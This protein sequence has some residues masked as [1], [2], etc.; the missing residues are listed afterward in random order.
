[1]QFDGIS[2]QLFAGLP[3]EQL[4]LFSCSHVVARENVLTIC[5]DTG[6]TNTVLDF[7]YD[8]RDSMVKSDQYAV[9]D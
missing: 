8:K 7:R 9:T 6:P 2:R 5:A 4:S 1:M 3:S